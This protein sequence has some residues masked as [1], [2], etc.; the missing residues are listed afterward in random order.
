MYEAC[1]VLVPI[2]HLYLPSLRA[3]MRERTIAHA[4][5]SMYRSNRADAN[6]V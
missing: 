2:M 3:S 1:T 4:T 6:T 5:K